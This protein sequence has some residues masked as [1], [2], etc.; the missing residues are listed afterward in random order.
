MIDKILTL[1]LCTSYLLLMGCD[2]DNSV[3]NKQTNCNVTIPNTLDSGSEAALYC[4]TFSAQWDDM[5]FSPVP[6]NAHFSDLIGAAVNSDSNLW[7][8]GEVASAGLEEVAETGKTTQFSTEINQDISENKALSIIQIPGTGAVGQATFELSLNRS[9]PLFTFATMIA[10]SP[11]WF[12]G[13]NQR[14]L[15]DANGQWLEE[16][17][18]ELPAY[19]AG[20]ESGDFFSLSGTQTSPAENI[21]RLNASIDPD[22]IFED[23]LVNEKSIASI[24]FVRI[25]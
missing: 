20:T 25:E 3:V 18:I 24:R 12:V 2:D 1:C 10:P 17:S 15:Q 8:R 7:R 13:L 22:I 14:A 4:V 19:D 9:F 5:T 16:L 23:G 11:D 21:T 6:S